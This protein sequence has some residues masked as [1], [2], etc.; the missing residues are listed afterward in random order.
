[1]NDSKMVGKTGSVVEG[2]GPLPLMKKSPFNGSPTKSVESLGS[3]TF[4]AKINSGEGSFGAASL[5]K[6]NNSFLT[7]LKKSGW[8]PCDVDGSLAKS[9]NGGANDIGGPM[10]IVD[11]DKSSSTIPMKKFF[12]K[13]FSTGNLGE[14][15]AKGDPLP[16]PPPLK[17]MQVSSRA[18]VGPGLLF[19]KKSTVS[20]KDAPLRES[21]TAEEAERV[22]IARLDDANAF[23]ESLK[24]TASMP[25][26]S[27]ATVATKTVATNDDGGI[28]SL[29]T[30][31]NYV[32]LTEG[33]TAEEAARVRSARLDDADA[34]VQTLKRN[35]LLPTSANKAVASPAIPSGSPMNLASDDDDTRETVMDFI[36]SEI[37]RE[38]AVSIYMNSSGGDLLAG[39]KRSVGTLN[40]DD[41]K[42]KGVAFG[43]LK[44][45]G[46]SLYPPQLPLKGMQ[47]S[48]PGSLKGLP[49]VKKSIS[50]GI[51][52]GVQKGEK[53]GTGVATENPTVGFQQPL[54]KDLEDDTPIEDIGTKSV[55]ESPPDVMEYSS[56]GI[57]ADA[58]SDD[59]VAS[60]S[61]ADNGVVA[62]LFD[63]VGNEEA[64]FASPPPRTGTDEAS[65]ERRWSTE[66][67]IGTGAS[68]SPKAFIPPESRPRPKSLEIFDAFIDLESANND[69]TYSYCVQDGR[70]QKQPMNLWSG[71][72]FYGTAS[73]RVYGLGSIR[74]SK[75]GGLVENPQE[76]KDR[77]INDDAAS[78]T[79]KSDGNKRITVNDLNADRGKETPR[80]D[81]EEAVVLAKRKKKEET[82]LKKQASEKMRL[83]DEK[84]LS[85]EKV[86]VAN[87]WLMQK[88]S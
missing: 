36:E 54:N 21:L 19:M 11:I 42:M 59:V 48:G 28:A 83:E 57:E 14:A 25:K 1:M 20:N 49:V 87:S 86:R 50:T 2:V 80:K 47:L 84:C 75:S 60:N 16:L 27:V 70:P 66:K 38:G 43:G 65:S 30:T 79:N 61:K 78:T 53:I 5:D 26:S 8:A 32:P 17:G 64:A 55:S 39:P 74:P 58:P 52:F 72:S 46:G 63:R 7:G 82:F 23:V 44:S 34:I 22:R 12:T 15:K 29:S 13:S 62:D 71:E 24:R 81:T 35:S 67:Q 41:G 45:K 18:N 31:E 69:G 76:N 10:K 37:D 77:A 3:I 33:L 85:E 9:I 4:Q 56:E 51:R 73:S 40:D 68:F 6:K 88:K